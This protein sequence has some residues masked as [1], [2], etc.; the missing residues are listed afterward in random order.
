M[1]LLADVLW[2]STVPLFIAGVAL[3]VRGERWFPKLMTRHRNGIV[4]NFFLAAV[5]AAIA[6]SAILK[7]YFPAEFKENL[8]FM[9]LMGVPLAVA[10]WVKRNNRF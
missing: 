3:D 10:F 7:Q 2:Y 9:L 5:I 4:A 8:P 1:H 6:Q